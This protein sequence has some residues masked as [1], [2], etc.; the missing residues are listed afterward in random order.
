MATAETG[1]ATDLAVQSR[2]FVWEFPV[3]PEAIWPILADTARFN[4][5]AHLPKHEIIETP[6]DD[7]SVLYEGRAR[8]GPFA[9]HWREKPVNWVANRWFEHCRDFQRGP[10][11][12]LCAKLILTRTAAGCRGEYIVQAAPATLFGRVLLATHF[13]ESAGRTFG[14]LAADAARYAAGKSTAAFAYTP[15]EFAPGVRERIGTLCERIEASGNGHG[16]TGRLRDLILTAQEVDLT[17]IRPLSLAREWQVNERDTIELCLQAARVGLLDLRWDILCP[18][19][20]VAKETVTALDRLP[21]GAHCGSC[22]I[23]YDRDFSRNVELSF[24]PSPA[25]RPLDSGE[26]CLFGPM[27]TPH[28]WAHLTLAPGETRILE[29]ELP[30]GAYRLRTLEP[31]PEADID[32]PGGEGQEGE[33]QGGFPEVILDADAIAAGPP[34]EPGHLTITNRT[35]RELT[36]IVEEL[37]WVRDALTADRVT[38]LQAFR[39]L[40]SD[41]VL[42]PGDEVSVRRVAFMFTDLRGSTAL[43]SRIGDAT[44]YHL[45]R[46]HFAF[47]AR[48]VRAHNGAIV[49]TIGDAIMAAFGDPADSLRAALAIQEGVRSFNAETDEDDLVIKIGL[50][51]GPSIAVTLN[52]R[53]DYFGSTV[54]MA[55]RVQAQSHGGDIVLSRD[56][57]EDAA[58]APLLEPY[59]VESES[60]ALKG[61]DAPVTLLRLV[62]EPTPQRRPR[63]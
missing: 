14:A 32:W 16:L 52:E 2:T 11:R 9:L 43:Y 62:P 19:C 4:E 30:P 1:N 60:I 41:Q 39:D 23:D 59:E 3:P 46:E 35:G 27:S 57:A 40:F 36:A 29:V 48:L 26:Y 7:G 54:N 38:A 22:N 15:P 28:I 31:G 50:H 33:G 5:A 37:R 44:A 12:S 47:L 45:V 18:R 56:I 20:R 49:K 24:E 10:L 55:A 8:M 6:R 25:V 17:R 13:F 34:A 42:R 63:A 51:Q 61:F 21:T 58:V 53:L